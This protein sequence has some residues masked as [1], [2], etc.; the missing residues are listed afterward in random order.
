MTNLD[1]EGPAIGGEELKGP[2][3]WVEAATPEG[4]GHPVEWFDEVWVHGMWLPLGVYCNLGHIYFIYILLYSQ[5]C[6][7][8]HCRLKCFKS[9]LIVLHKNGIILTFQDEKVD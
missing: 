1:W 6:K 8:F 7:N 3:G 4:C 2:L 5:K 9:P